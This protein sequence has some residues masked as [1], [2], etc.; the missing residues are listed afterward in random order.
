MNKHLL[1]DLLNRRSIQSLF[2]IF[3]VN[4][5]EICLVGGCVRDALS[6]KT[7]GDIDIAA[8]VAPD[9]IIEILKINKLK[10]EDYAYKYGSINIYIE[11]K[12]FQITTLREDVNQIGRHTDIIFTQNWE[13]D[14]SRRDFTINAIYISR[15]CQI[16][17]F[18][19]GQEDLTNSTLR[20]VG[21]IEDSIQ[22]DFL[23]IFRYYRFLGIFAEPK[24]IKEYDEILLNYCEKSFDVLSND[25]IRQEILKM[26][27]SPFPL[28]SFFD[29]KKTIEKKN[30]VQLTKKH[31]IKTGYEIGLT[32]CLNKIDLLIN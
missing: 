7:I 27:N 14:A 21:N 20:F 31:F 32:R 15:N 17:D 1:F 4:S 19:N 18:F 24:L 9:E 13:K 6:G 26:F 10:Y 11:N 30:W 23:R 5:K 25:L 28:N 3:N 16:K 29:N 12:K 22:E 2:D 8:Q